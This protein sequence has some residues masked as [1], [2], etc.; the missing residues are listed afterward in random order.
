MTYPLVSLPLLCARMQPLHRSDEPE[1]LA[2]SFSL[3]YPIEDVGRV[4]CIR[5][6]TMLLLRQVRRRSSD[7]SGDPPRLDAHAHGGC[8]QAESEAGPPLYPYH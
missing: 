7:G 2:G 6:H 5:I 3:T 1:S 8:R 4:T